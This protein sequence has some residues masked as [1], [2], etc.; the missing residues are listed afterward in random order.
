MRSQDEACKAARLLIDVARPKKGGYRNYLPWHVFEALR[1]LRSGYAGRPQLSRALGLGEA[2]VKTMLSELERLGL[3]K[4]SRRGRSATDRGAAIVDIIEK[5]IMLNKIELLFFPGRRAV[6]ILVASAGPPRDL[7]R[8]YEIR[9][10][11]VT[12]GCRTALIGGSDGTSIFFPGV[13]FSITAKIHI[14]GNLPEGT[15][16]IAPAKCTLEAASAGLSV[17]AESCVH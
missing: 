8:V 3:V 2:S 1:I 16:I 6:I 7:T 12:Y 4:R 17:L 5:H 11:L 9:D 10:H 15:I 14:P 13:P